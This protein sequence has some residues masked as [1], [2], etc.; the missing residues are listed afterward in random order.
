MFCSHGEALWI[1]WGSLSKHTFCNQQ[2]S[3]HQKC[4]YTVK[5]NEMKVTTRAGNT[6]GLWLLHSK[7]TKI[8]Y[9]SYPTQLVDHLDSVSIWDMT[10]DILISWL[11]I[12]CANSSLILR[13]KPIKQIAF[14]YTFFVLDNFQQIHLGWCIVSSP[15]L[16][17]PSGP[18]SWCSF[19]G[20]ACILHIDRVIRKE[21]LRLQE[22]SQVMHSKKLFL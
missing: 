22:V 3:D 15:R 21:F 4:L 13:Q 11:S 8:K 16:Q 6:L 1:G 20:K 19:I 5:R 9:H 14:S 10:S 18:I 7:Y 12:F 2:Y 17:V